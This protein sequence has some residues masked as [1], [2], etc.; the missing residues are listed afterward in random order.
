MNPSSVLVLVDALLSVRRTCTPTVE[1]EQAEE[2]LCYLLARDQRLEIPADFGRVIL[3][4]EIGWHEI[5][6][7]TI[8]VYEGMPIESGDI[9]NVFHIAERVL[10][11]DQPGRPKGRQKPPSFDDD[12]PARHDSKPGRGTKEVREIAS[13]VG[14]WDP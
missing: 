6:I 13:T 7:T 14:S 8:E 10:G 12:P 9:H 11:D 5:A 2:F 1:G 4:G 3:R